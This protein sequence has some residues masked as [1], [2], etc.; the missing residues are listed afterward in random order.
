MKFTIDRTIYNEDT[1]TT[2]VIGKYHFLRTINT[3]KMF[4]EDLNEEMNA[5]IG[6][7]LF[8]MAQAESDPSAENIAKLTDLQFYETRHELLKYMYAEKNEAGVLVQGEKTREEFEELDDL[9]DSEA[10]KSFFRSI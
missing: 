7:L 3:E 1:M 9:S 10:L 6:E 8:I 5:Q 4:R 2:E